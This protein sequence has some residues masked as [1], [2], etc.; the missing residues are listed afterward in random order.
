MCD[1]SKRV[2]LSIFG[3]I[4]VDSYLAKKSCTG[5]NES[6]HEFFSR[7]ADQMIDQGRITRAQKRVLKEA[8]AIAAD[9]TSRK[10]PASAAMSS[11]FGPHLTPTKKKRSPD[12]AG[13]TSTYA[14]QQRCSCCSKK[15][16][17]SCS[18]CYL[19]DDK[20][21]ALCHTR[22]RDSC[23]SDHVKRHHGVFQGTCNTATI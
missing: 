3:M 6:P 21:V 12:K 22:L 10:R 20:I 4:V 9:S 16:T 7:L 13:K 17:W 11:G 5:V 14:N 2:N 1:W 23:W 15:T 18:E 8:D 19:R